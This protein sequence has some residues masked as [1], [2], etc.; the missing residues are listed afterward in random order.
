MIALT[1]VSYILNMLIPKEQE[2][3]NRAQATVLCRFFLGWIAEKYPELYRKLLPYDGREQRECYFLQPSKESDPELYEQ[4]V[5]T[6]EVPLGT[7]CS[8]CNKQLNRLPYYYCIG[9]KTHRCIECTE[10]QDETATNRL[11]RYAIN[12]NSIL[13]IADRVVDQVRLG[14]NIQPT[15]QQECKQHSFVCNGCA[16]QITNHPRYICLGCRRQPNFFHSQ[17]VDFCQKCARKLAS[18]NE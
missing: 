3:S 7:S 6:F 8:S 5:K 1:N 11:K 15:T 12:E 10:K 2:E 18:S 16:E 13:L 14:R 9:S 4:I 17:P